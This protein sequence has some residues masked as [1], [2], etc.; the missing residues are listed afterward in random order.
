VT[1]PQRI[2]TLFDSTCLIVGII[3]GVGIYQVA[4]DVAR[5]VG[6]PLGLLGLWVIGGVLSLCGALCYAELATT[7]P[8]QGGDYV[9]LT[10]AYGPG[11]GFVFG[12]A[13]LAI[14]RP[15]DI[16]VVAFAFATYANTLLDPFP[17][18][19]MFSG[20]RSY[21]LLAVAALTF[22][23]VLGVR[24]GKWTQNLLTLVKAAGLLFIG[25][26]GFL[27]EPAKP[28]E[29]VDRLP[30]SLALIFVLFC[31]GGWNEMAYVAAE[32]QNPRRNILRALVLGTLGVLGLYLVVN[33]AFLTALGF[34]GVQSS[35]A[36]AT[37]TLNAFLPALGG[38][39]VSVLICISAL[40]ALN[41][42]IFTGAR[43]SYAVGRDHPLFRRFGRWNGRRGTP[44]FALVS[45]GLIAGVLV[46]VLG[47]FLHAILYTASVVYT[48][49]LATTLAL[50]VLRFREPHVDRPYRVTFYPLVPGLFAGVCLF[51]VFS[52][53]AYE[54]VIAVA[55]LGLLLAGWPLYAFSRSQHR[56]RPPR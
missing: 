47:S 54:P 6:G 42:L 9:Y 27:A 1:Q 38:A 34:E 35:G 53:I 23:N 14:V 3:I 41:G 22:I 28:V 51:L 48:F 13:Q 21:A 50:I 20:P 52:A 39:G 32:V 7:Y 2:L 10:R 25:V 18:T 11:A 5:G 31:F 44:V 29:S 17:E 56:A 30:L 15:G 45:Q 36:V 40:G 26:A 16:A 43:I 46:V 4:P 19:G 12:W 8:E 33:V 49:Y 55:A 24:E 37:D